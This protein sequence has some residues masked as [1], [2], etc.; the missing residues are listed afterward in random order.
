M[1]SASIANF[2]ELNILALRP[3]EKR[4][5]HGRIGEL[6]LE[7]NHDDGS[8]SLTAIGVM[9]CRSNSD[10]ENKLVESQLSIE[11]QNHVDVPS[12]AASDQ[13]LGDAS[14]LDALQHSCMKQDRSSG[15]EQFVPLHCECRG[16]LSRTAQDTGTEEDIIYMQNKVDESQSLI[17]DF[18]ALVKLCKQEIVQYKDELL[19]SS[20]VHEVEVKQLRDTIHR[21]SEEFDILQTSIFTKDTELIECSKKICA[22]EETLQFERLAHTEE[23]TRLSCLSRPLHNLSSSSSPRPHASSSSSGCGP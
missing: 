10:L 12:R 17:N 4:K 3:A 1:L 8:K 16:V 11:V 5:E 19:E 6:S 18:E 9:L 20:A 13:N 15:I 23:I 22:L 14:R 7:N 2:P 21:L